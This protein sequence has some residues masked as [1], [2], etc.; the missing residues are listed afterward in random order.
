MYVRVCVFLCEC[1]AGTG[2]L[3]HFEAHVYIY[4]CMYMY[5]RIY[6]NINR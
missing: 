5:V 3:R 1:V 4:I 6:S 2:V